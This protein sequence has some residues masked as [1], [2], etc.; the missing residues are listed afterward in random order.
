MT[1][2]TGHDFVLM[3]TIAAAY[4]GD[5]LAGRDVGRC[6]EYKPPTNIIVPYDGST[7]AGEVQIAAAQ[8]ARHVLESGADFIRDNRTRLAAAG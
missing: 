3:A 2:P 4:S 6:T 1:V 7:D 5:D 8:D